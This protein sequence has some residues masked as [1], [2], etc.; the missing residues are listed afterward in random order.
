MAVVPVGKGGGIGKALVGGGGVQNDGVDLVPVA[1]VSAREAIAGI[2]GRAGL[3]ADVAILAQQIVV[4]VHG[5]RMVGAVGTGDLNPG[6]LARYDLTDRVILHSFLHHQRH[7]VCSRVHVA[8]PLIKVQ[9]M[10][11]LKDRAGAAEFLGA[12]VHG[13]NKRRLGVLGLGVDLF[14]HV[15]GKHDGGVVARG[16]HQ[17]AQGLLH[18]ELV[19]FEQAGS[20]VAYGGRG[21][22]HRHLLVHLAVLDGQDCSHY[23]GDRGDLDLFVGIAGIVDGAVFAHDE[24]IGRIDIG[25][26]LSRDAARI[27]GFAAHVVGREHLGAGNGGYANSKGDGAGKAGGQLGRALCKRGEGLHRFRF[28]RDGLFWL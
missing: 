1:V 14:A 18:G 2:V 25:Q 21:V 9:T 23:L 13:L 22:A 11:V 4:R 24:G 15:L 20:R 6:I 19:A 7:V 26:V 10:R 28:R 8:S 5:M 17:A 27:G 16:N 12:L 3:A